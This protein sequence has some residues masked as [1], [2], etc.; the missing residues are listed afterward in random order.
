VLFYVLDAKGNH[1][2]VSL[3]PGARYAICTENGPQT[4]PCEPFL[5][6]RSRG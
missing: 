2:G 4:L 5:S 3:L 6:R 1:A